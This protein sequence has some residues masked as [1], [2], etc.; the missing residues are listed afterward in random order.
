MMMRD[1]GTKQLATWV[2]V[3][4]GMAIQ[5]LPFAYVLGSKNAEFE[6]LKLDHQQHCADFHRLEERIRRHEIQAAN[7][8]PG[9]FSND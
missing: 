2:Q 3:A 1:G 5:A 7:A 4:I 6:R 8:F 9:K